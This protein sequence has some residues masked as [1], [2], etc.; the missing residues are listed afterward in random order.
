MVQHDHHR[1]G[2]VCKITDQNDRPGGLFLGSGV[3]ITESAVFSRARSSPRPARHRLHVMINI[4]VLIIHPHWTS[5]AQRY[6]DQ[7]LAQTRQ[8]TNGVRDQLPQDES[9]DHQ[10]F[11]GSR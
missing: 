8:R 7:P 11:P 2:T 4:E 5:A 6:L 3:R 9:S 1:G 10:A